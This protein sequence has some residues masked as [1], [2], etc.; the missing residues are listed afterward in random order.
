MNMAHTQ[1]RDDFNGGFDSSLKWSWK[2]PGN[3]PECTGPDPGA[4][5][6]SPT[7]LDISM[8]NGALFMG[9]NNIH[10]VPSLKLRGSQPDDW[11]IETAFRI[12]W[13]PID[14]FNYV[15][16]G[17]VL[18]SDAANYFQL[19]VTRDATN[20]TRN[21]NG[22]TNVELGDAFA[23]GERTSNPWEPN[24]DDYIGLR[25]EHV[26][27]ESPMIR[28]L[29]RRSPNEEWREFET[30][31]PATGPYQFWDWQ[32]GAIRTILDSPNVQVGL[33]ADNAGGGYVNTWSFDYFETNLNVVMG[34]DVNGDGCVDDSDL[35]AVLFAFGNTGDCMDEDLN[36][37]GMVDDIDLL[38]V[39]F[40]FGNGC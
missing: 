38:A 3:N 20:Q 2:V 26:P 12:N 25:V 27:G 22:S 17:I 6:F 14:V 39:L 19:L 31:W 16:A 36:G 35:L 21:V 9:F 30:G 5:S 15:Q 23:W 13:D 32:Y 11:Y 8:R 10:N 33:Y 1:V 4:V 28:L 7:S 18:F 37:D 24:N 29:Y 40:A 34:G